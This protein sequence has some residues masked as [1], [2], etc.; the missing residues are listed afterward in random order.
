MDLG[1]ALILA[2]TS[3]VTAAFNR[4]YGNPPVGGAYLDCITAKR[5]VL[6]GLCRKRVAIST[7]FPPSPNTSFK[8][9]KISTSS[10]TS[11]DQKQPRLTV[12]EKKKVIENHLIPFRATLRHLVAGQPQYRHY[13]ER[14]FFPDSV[15]S[16][17]LHHFFTIKS[18]A[19]IVS[20]SLPLEVFV[21]NQNQLLFSLVITAQNS[22][23]SSRRSAKT[24][25]QKERD[26]RADQGYLMDEASDI[27]EDSTTITSQPEMKP[28]LRNVTNA[29]PAK[30]P[31]K[32]KQKVLSCKEVA[33]GFGPPKTNRSRTRKEN[34]G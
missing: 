30:R 5:R 18:I 21:P 22:I 27:D 1:K 26:A 14:M 16:S 31:R 32:A 4:Y 3:C 9:F 2:E 24:R 29:P 6:C 20:I 7:T 10:K 33:Q 23:H 34:I 28:I 11:A 19:D 17:L 25:K 15:I 13:V 12:A 8:P